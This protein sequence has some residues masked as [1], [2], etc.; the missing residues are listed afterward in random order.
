MRS[1]IGR[2]ASIRLFELVHRLKRERNLDISIDLGISV[3]ISDLF[4]GF[5][6]SVGDETQA[7]IFAGEEVHGEGISF[8]FVNLSRIARLEG[9]FDAKT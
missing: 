1:A 2:V 6:I 3:G 4:L 5:R 9:I 7:R 8:T